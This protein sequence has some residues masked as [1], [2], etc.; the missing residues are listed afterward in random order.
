MLPIS[1]TTSLAR[2]TADYVWIIVAILVVVAHASHLDVTFTAF[3]SRRA[4]IARVV[5]VARVFV[6]C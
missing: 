2:L 3:K 5:T 6:A 1:I 4:S